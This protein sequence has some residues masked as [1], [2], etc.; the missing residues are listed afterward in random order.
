MI[1]VTMTQN[2]WPALHRWDV[3]PAEARIIQSE[4]AAQ[5]IRADPPDFAPRYVAGVDVGFE[6]NGEVTRA[7]V[8]VLNLDDLMPVDCAIA[9]LPTHFPYVPGLLSFREIPAVLEALSLLDILPDVLLC[10]GQGIAHPRRLGIAAHLGVLTGLPSAGVAKSLLTGTHAAVPELPG[11]WTPLLDQKHGR[12]EIIGAVLRTRAGCKPLYV[13]NGHRLS[14]DTAITLT[15]R[16]T[17][18]Y[19]L[20]ETTRWADGIASRKLPIVR[21]LPAPLRHRLA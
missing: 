12:N 10:D 14:L 21:H 13:S 1:A 15:L 17:T 16:C 6:N 5:V 7:A 3:T 19:R 18:R 4:L 9:R 8:V 20:P 2:R 11:E